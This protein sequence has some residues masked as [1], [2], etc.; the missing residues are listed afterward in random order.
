MWL[1]QEI[2]GPLIPVQ[3]FSSEAEVLRTA[4][5]SQYGLAGYFFSKDHDRIWRVARGLEVGMV[6]A[7]TGMISAQVS[8]TPFAFSRPMCWPMQIRHGWLICKAIIIDLI[9]I[10]NLC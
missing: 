2:F 7:N 4:N 1:R 3:S 8:S 10:C 6:G 9:N 5:S